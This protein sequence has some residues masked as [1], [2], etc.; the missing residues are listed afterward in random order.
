MVDAH[1]QVRE[2]AAYKRRRQGAE[3]ARERAS[4][5]KVCAQEGVVPRCEHNSGGKTP[6]GASSHDDEAGPTRVV[7]QVANDA[8]AGPRDPFLQCGR[9]ARLSFSLILVVICLNF[10][11][12]PDACLYLSVQ[13]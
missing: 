6:I 8:E 1:R 13:F 5:G 4:R 2:A 12:N 7:G 9:R 10:N 11:E 3:R